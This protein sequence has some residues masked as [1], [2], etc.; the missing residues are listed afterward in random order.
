MRGGGPSVLVL[1]GVTMVEFK[2]GVPAG[3][4]TFRPVSIFAFFYQETFSEKTMARPLNVG[5]L[6][7]VFIVEI[8]SLFGLKS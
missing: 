6:I 8:S 7:V 5:A 1:I 4:V 3:K 2:S